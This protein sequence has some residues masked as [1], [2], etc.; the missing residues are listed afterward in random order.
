M[1]DHVTEEEAVAFATYL[2]DTGSRVDVRDDILNST[3][4][5]WA[6]RWGRAGV[7]KV[8][9]ERGAAPV[10][11]DAEPWAQPRVGRKDGAQPRSHFASGIPR[12]ISSA[13]L[14]RALALRIAPRAQLN[15]T[16]V[17][18]ARRFVASFARIRPEPG[19]PM[20]MPPCPLLILHGCSAAH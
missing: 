8:M 17:Q 19:I 11:A 1:R 3:P 5:G 15:T 18:L 14:A 4:L 2:L 7:A 12:L 13:I 6:C 9:L 20:R 10:E 16:A